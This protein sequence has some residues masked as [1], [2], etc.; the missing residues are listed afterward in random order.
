MFFC[1]VFLPALFVNINAATRTF[2]DVDTSFFIAYRT[3]HR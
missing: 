2:E 3:V 1:S